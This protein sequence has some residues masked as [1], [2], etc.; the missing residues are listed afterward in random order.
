TLTY[1]VSMRRRE[2]GLRLALGALRGQIVSRFLKQ[3]IRACLIGCIAGIGLAA[4][5][6]RAL[7]SMLFG[8]SSWDAATFAAVVALV[9]VTGAAASLIPAL[10]ASRVEPM[11][12]LRDE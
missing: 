6:S 1:F 9:L 8:I 10:R 12:V 3:G 11:Q 4:A 7:A 5:F 2:V